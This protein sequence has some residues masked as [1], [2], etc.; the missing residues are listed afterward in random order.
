[1][2]KFKVTLIPLAILFLSFAFPNCFLIQCKMDKTQDSIT[3]SSKAFDNGGNIPSKYTCDTENVSPPLA[4]TKGPNN[5]KT[6][7]LICDDPDAPSKTW[8]HW[9]LFNIPSSVN[10]LP[11]NLPT[12]KSILSGAIQGKNDFK[13]TGYS[14]PCPP[15][16]THR[17]YFKVYALDC[18]L[19]L[20]SHAQ[21][22]DVETAMKDHILAKGVLM[23]KYKRK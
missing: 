7:V 20:D 2:K 9:V 1:M 8:V 23:G 17:Y 10:E 11:E 14:G 6:Y 12:E 19:S 5:T 15:S 3:V 13:T 18:E 22:E 21:K 4:W 16:G